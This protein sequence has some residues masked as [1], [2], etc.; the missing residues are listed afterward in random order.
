MADDPTTDDAEELLTPSQVARLFRVT[1][2]T[3]T[4]WADQS[5]LSCVRTLGGH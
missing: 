1:P 4:R 3:V 5:V 2:K